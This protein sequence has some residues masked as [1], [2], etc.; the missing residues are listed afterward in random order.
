MMRCEDKVAS[1]VTMRSKHSDAA[2]CWDVKKIDTKKGRSEGRIL[3]H[4]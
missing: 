2:Y 1:M 3:R 4:D